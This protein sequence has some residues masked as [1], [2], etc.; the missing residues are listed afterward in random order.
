MLSQGNYEV[1]KLSGSD[2]QVT[3]SIVK[4]LALGSAAPCRIEFGK[5]IT[6]DTEFKT[7][8]IVAS[9]DVPDGTWIDGPAGRMS[10]S[11]Y[12]VYLNK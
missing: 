2:C 1:R 11:N 8:G 7:T 3:G 5:H 10:G 6:P 4:A 12:L 9:L